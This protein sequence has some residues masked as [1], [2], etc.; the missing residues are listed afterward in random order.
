MGDPL[1]DIKSAL[2]AI[3]RP[4]RYCGFTLWMPTWATDEQIAAVQKL[5]P[6]AKVVRGCDGDHAHRTTEQADG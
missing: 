2:S 6:G 3:Y 5:M 1:N 4:W